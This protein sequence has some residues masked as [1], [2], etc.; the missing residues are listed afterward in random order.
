MPSSSTAVSI[1]I[2][3][4]L[5]ELHRIRFVQRDVKPANGLITE[6]VSTGKLH[7]IIAD[8]NLAGYAAEGRTCTTTCGTAEYMTPE[9]L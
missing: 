6:E 5:V 1:D 9:V 2:H 7:F 4:S 8:F 3:I